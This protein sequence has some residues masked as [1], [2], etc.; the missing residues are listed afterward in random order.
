MQKYRKYYLPFILFCFLG[1]VIRNLG[2]SELVYFGGDE[3]RHFMNGV[4]IKDLIADSG[5]RFPLEY[6]KWFY[7][8]YPALSIHQYPPL[9]YVLEAIVF[10]LFG[11][12][13][14]AIQIMIFTI[15]GLSFYYWYRYIEKKFNSEIALL[16]LLVFMSTPLFLNNFSR[17]MLDSFSLSLILIFIYT[18]DLWYS[19]GSRKHL[20]LSV[21]LL[22]IILSIAFKTYFL[23]FYVL[24][25]VAYQRF[26]DKSVRKRWM[27]LL[28]SFLFIF[29]LFFIFGTLSRVSGIPLLYRTLQGLN[30][31][32][33]Y[34]VKEFIRTRDMAM[35][36]HF[37]FLK[38]FG[39]SGILLTLVGIL[40]I[41]RHKKWGMFT[42]DTLYAVNFL[43]IF[44]FC[45]THFEPKRFNLFLLPFVALLSGYALY[46][47][48][49]MFKGKALYIGLT[50][51]ILFFMGRGVSHPTMYARGYEN[52]ARDLIA[53]NKHDQPVLCDDYLDGNFIAY[54]RKYDPLKQQIIFRGDKLLFV[55]NVYYRYIKETYV[56]NEEDIYTIL[57]QYGIRY[58]VVDNLFLDIKQKAILR[59]TLKN[60]ERFRY[61]K[62]Y[63]MVTN[64]QAYEHADLDIYEYLHYRT[65]YNQIVNISLPGMNTT[66][67]FT[68]NDLRKPAGFDR[69]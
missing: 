24:L 55:A 67:S 23:L 58:I 5:W 63:Q 1:L 15:T 68:V 64:S 59:N 9:F 40:F 14:T 52:A 28:V 27:A 66:Y 7:L 10:S 60:K 20:S 50:G 69:N 32:S 13:V 29:S 33:I 17:I 30:M 46:N 19:S 42:N 36:F 21:A 47:L 4:F 2:K 43:F 48:V 26:S 25:L 3:S 41:V 39:I 11:I 44:T 34:K 49:N 37:K 56:E 8:K 31:M 65:D 18:L 38:I 22:L 57:D 54:I 62:T 53:L 45:I 51:I 6:L 61:I 12:H 35:F 16:S